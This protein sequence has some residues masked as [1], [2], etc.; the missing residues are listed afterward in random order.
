MPVTGKQQDKSGQY[1]N[2]NITEQHAGL[3]LNEKL[4][5]LNTHQEVQNQENRRTAYHGPGAQIQ[6][7]R[8]IHP[9][10]DRHNNS[11]RNGYP[12]RHNQPGSQKSHV[13][14]N[15]DR[16]INQL[17]AGSV[18][19][20][21]KF[22]VYQCNRKDCNRHQ[23]KSKKCTGAAITVENRIPVVYKGKNRACRYRINKNQF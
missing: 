21:S 22:A 8:L 16:I 10:H 1:G 23:G 4:D 2:R 19:Q 17:P 9:C 13:F 5:I 11:R 6:M 3:G 20:R 18:K 14:V 15:P 7:H 12:G